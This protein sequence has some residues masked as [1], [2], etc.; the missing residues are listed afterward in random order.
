MRR[1]LARPLKVVAAEVVGKYLPSKALQGELL[2]I[3]IDQQTLLH[4]SERERKDLLAKY[5]ESVKKTNGT[6]M[7][8]V[9]EECARPVRA[10]NPKLDTFSALRQLMNEPTVDQCLTDAGYP[11]KDRE[12]ALRSLYS[13]MN[14]N[15]HFS[16][17]TKTQTWVLV[18]GKVSDSFNQLEQQIVACF[19]EAAPQ[20]TIEPLQQ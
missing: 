8:D 2:E 17:D 1:L 20:I 12:G 15:Q 4:N 16:F 18:G 7:R 6:L 10:K 11:K 9:L 3:A 14:S 19:L 5:L 13:K